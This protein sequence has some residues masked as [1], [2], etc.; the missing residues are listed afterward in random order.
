MNRKE[1]GTLFRQRSARIFSDRATC[2]RRLL[3][4]FRFLQGN[5]AIPHD[6]DGGRVRSVRWPAADRRRREPWGRRTPNMEPEGTKPK[7]KKTRKGKSNG[8]ASPAGGGEVGRWGELVCKSGGTPNPGFLD[9]NLRTC[10]GVK[11]P[12]EK[13]PSGVALNNKGGGKRGREPWGG[14]TKPKQFPGVTPNT[15]ERRGKT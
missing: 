1:G 15:E 2:F 8:G 13:T 12:G 7:A 4:L 10:C 5:Q 3:P 9:Q 11:F 6:S 14:T